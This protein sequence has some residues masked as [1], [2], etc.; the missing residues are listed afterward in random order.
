[1]AYCATHHWVKDFGG[2]KQGKHVGNLVPKKEN[3][4]KKHY[5][6]RRLFVNQ[7]LPVEERKGKVYTD[8]S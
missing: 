8:K 5:Y 3:I 6:L 2:Y 4:A 7:A 1:M